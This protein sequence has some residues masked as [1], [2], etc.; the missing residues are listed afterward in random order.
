M[1]RMTKILALLL[2]MG[3]LLCACSGG[4]STT[5]PADTSPETS[6]PETTLAPTPAPTESD[7]ET[8]APATEPP[9]T[10]TAPTDTGDNPGGTAQPSEPTEGDEE[11]ELYVVYG[12]WQFNE[13]LT[14]PHLTEEEH[15]WGCTEEITFQSNGKVYDRWLDMRAWWYDDTVTCFVLSYSALSSTGVDNAYE[16]YDTPARWTDENYRTVDFG[17][18]PQ[19]VSKEFYQWFVKNA[20][21][22]SA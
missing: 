8:T 11:P 13:T 18:Y 21:Q 16:S 4:G 2:A 12:V 6:T 15:D 22:V 7:P 20:Q 5:A 19:S 1:K 17:A 14:F 10:T 3:T 9:A